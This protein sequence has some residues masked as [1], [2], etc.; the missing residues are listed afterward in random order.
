VG[1]VCGCDGVTYANACEASA[2]AT[3]VDTEGACDGG[4]GPV[5]CGGIQGL[6]CA[7]GEF[8]FIEDGV[9]G[10]DVEGV[11]VKEPEEC[12]ED[13]KPVCGCDGRTYVNACFAA[14][15][16]AVVDGPGACEDSRVCGGILGL[17]CEEGLVCVIES[18]TCDDFARGK[19]FKLPPECSA[20]FEP[21]CGCDDVTYDN[22]CVAVKAGA[23]IAHKGECDTG[24]ACGGMD[25]MS[26]FEG[27]ACWRGIGM[28]SDMD[29]GKCIPAPETCPLVSDPVCGCDGVTY[30]NACGALAAD[31]GIESL[32]ACGVEP[33][34]CGGIGGEKCG[35]EEV[36]FLKPGV[37]DGQATGRCVREPAECLVPKL[38]VCGCDGETYN[39]L[40][41]ATLE[42]VQV[43]SEGE[44]A[45]TPDPV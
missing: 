28:C 9:C 18:Q 16:G 40:C 30:D 25:G 33:V 35:E 22:A 31:A 26:C 27:E 21:V 5:V 4:G 32:R 43:E 15:A 8:C 24:L 1:L 13:L 17:E 41:D 39:S 23:P 38:P 37:C 10:E 20:E 3:S 42:G 29:P 19:C 36:C 2:A 34:L 44:C 6:T 14:K 45:L 7:E 12:P 11:C